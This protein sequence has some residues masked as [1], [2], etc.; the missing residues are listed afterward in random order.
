MYVIRYLHQGLQLREESPDA[1]VDIRRKY[2]Q[3]GKIV[4]SITR[5]YSLRGVPKEEVIAFLTAMGDQAGAGVHT[6]QALDNI[7]ASFPDT[8]AFIP[9][10]KKIRASVVEGTPI[11]EAM[12]QY[13][14]V[15]GHSA[16][17]MIEAGEHSGQIGETFLTSADF[18]ASQDEINKNLWQQLSKPLLTFM[19]GLAS[20]LINSMFVIPKLMNT[21]LFKNASGGKNGV[22][23][24]AYYCMALL[25]AMSIIVP[26]SLVLAVVA[27]GASIVMYK[28][29]QEK[30]EEKI[31]RIPGLR[32]FIFFR[33]YF[34][35]FS[36]LS[37]LVE[38]G[39]PLGDAFTIIEKSTGF[40]ILRRQFA[41]ARATINEGQH[42]TKALTALTAVER[43]ILMTAQDN[44]RIHK[45]FQDTAKRYHRLYLK[46]VASV[47]PKIQAA[48]IA[49]VV[50]IFVLEFF[51][52]MLPYTKILGSIH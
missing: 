14:H 7:L 37:K 3:D 45:S 28:Q 49:L 10:L 27:I 35:A 29:H 20:L 50:A 9:V 25:N 17:A 33:A 5:S 1:P 6:T 42:F 34:V 16:L 18:I 21:A 41:A 23:D 44:S 48:V 40:I 47:G 24:A 31:I 38:V 39:V 8:S 11:S 43:S 52:I 26:S 13:P 4:L 30:V 32:E 19:F 36:S 22:H 15:F 12:K 46:K 2:A 51:G